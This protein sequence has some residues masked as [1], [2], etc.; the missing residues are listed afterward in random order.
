MHREHRALRLRPY[1]TTGVAIVGASAIAVAPIQ[2]TPQDVQVPN[3]TVQLAPPVELAA[4]EIEDA[5]NQLTFVGAEVL[6]S[7]AKLPAPLVAQLL[8]MEPEEAETFLAIGSLGLFGPLISGPGGVGAAVQDI[9]DGLGTGDPVG[10]LNALIGAPATIIDGIVNGNFGP[11]VASLISEMF[12]TTLTGG[13]INPG[14]ILMALPPWTVPG[15][16]PTLQGLVTQLLDQLGGGEMM[17]TALVEEPRQIEDAFNSL[18]FLGTQILV[19]LAQIPAPI[20]APILGVPEEEAAALLAVGS[21]GLLGSL[22]SGTGATGAAIQNV[23]NALGSGDIGGVLN[24]LIGAPA[25]LID[26]VVNGGYG[27]N[28][29]PL[30]EDQLIGLDPQ[31]ALA[32]ATLAAIGEPFPTVL[33]GG[34]INN[35]GVA[36][37]EFTVPTPGGPVEVELPV[38]ITLPGF[39]PTVQDLVTQVVDPPPEAELV[40]T[41]DIDDA[42]FAT[43]TGLGDDDL[44]DDI[45]DENG[46]DDEDGEGDGEGGGGNVVNDNNDDGRGNVVN[47]NNPG[48]TD[49]GNNTE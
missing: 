16:I 40:E 46:I 42:E 21:V 14:N 43:F 35:Q 6:V 25:T 7:L 33:A 23:V 24:A 48:P 15:V 49:E 27:P 30:L 39:V 37:E 20:V 32:A 13:L 31:L 19:T 26:G 1:L 36:L 11:N 47:D 29:S 45:I 22:I 10:I 44:G 8:D 9:V 17:A 2:F 3:P 28:L 34:L 5:I 41:T 18:A 12:P 38:E 4:S